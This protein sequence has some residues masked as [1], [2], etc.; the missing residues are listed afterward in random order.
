MPKAQQASGP[1]ALGAQRIIKRM[2]AHMQAVP[3]GARG[4]D[5][6]STSTHTHAI[7]IWGHW[8]RSWYWPP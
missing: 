8:L 3:R 6:S 7:F 5:A 2:Q 4:C 1:R